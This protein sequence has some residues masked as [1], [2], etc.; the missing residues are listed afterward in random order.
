MIDHGRF[1]GLPWDDFCAAVA[2]GEIDTVM[3]AFVDM[4]G[5]LV[6]KRIPAEHFVD[7]VAEAGV[8]FCKYLLGTDMEMST[9]SGF[10]L[11]NWDEGYGDWTLAIDR[12]TL[13]RIPWLPG[14]ALVLGDVVDSA[15]QLVDIAPRAILRRQVER[16][17]RLGWEPIMA[18]EL[19]FYLWDETYE[20]V[21]QKG[22]QNLKTFGWYLEDYHL[23]Q[24]SKAEPFY[25]QV[26]NQM[27]EAGIP[28]IAAKGE[29][30][31][32][33]YEI[34]LAHGPALEVADHHAIYKHGIK[35]MAFSHNLAVSFM[36]KPDHTLTGSS[37]HVHVSLWDRARNVP[38]FAGEVPN[39]P[40]LSE[41]GQQFLAGL[42]ALS[43]EWTLLVAP[44]INSYKRYASQ[45]WAPVN[46]AWGYD[47][48][49][50]GIR[51]VGKGAQVHIENRLPGADANPY[52]TLAAV[53]AAGLWGIE[54]RLSCPPPVEGNAYAQED[55][56]RVPCR[57][58]EAIQ[59][60]EASEAAREAFGEE[61]VAH[62]LNAARVEQ[63][64]FD[65]V[66]TSWERQRYFER[67]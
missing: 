49:T 29:A 38:A 10:R 21:H 63:E 12:A 6:G 32:G 43:R 15:G 47:N 18:T 37:C 27:R 42:V 62:Y 1:R 34:N 66:V 2:T 22:Y 5:R 33:Q 8:H 48:R 60:W 3:A 57:L 16:A 4:Q 41:I 35:E 11:M 52:L 58:S 55:L 53:L 26:R 36:A 7:E 39:R 13:R 30:G 46:I 61:V 17:R 31:P 28:V 20:S 25:R 59:L 9:P 54:H 64:A 45:S 56:P 50:V 40:S 24:S 19:E 14:T 67:I 23:L 65:R 44:T 51:V